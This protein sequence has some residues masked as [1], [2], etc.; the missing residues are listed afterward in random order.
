METEHIHCHFLINDGGITCKISAKNV[1]ALLLIAG[2]ATAPWNGLPSDIVY[3]S[4]RNRA[5]SSLME[6]VGSCRD[7]LLQSGW[8]Y[9]NPCF[10][11]LWLYHLDFQFYHQRLQVSVQVYRRIRR[12]K[13]TLH[14][15]TP[16][17]T[18]KAPISVS[19]VTSTSI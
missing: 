14:Y 4:W 13:P 8:L 19:S 7:T 2:W 18:Q 11:V 15:S 16:P 10:C 6:E 12:R 3:N 9:N 5:F 17:V 1:R